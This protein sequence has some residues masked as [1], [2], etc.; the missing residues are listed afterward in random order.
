LKELK[1]FVLATRKDINK[2]VTVYKNAIFYA[3]QNL[4]KIT[5]TKDEGARIANHNSDEPATPKIQ[6][7]PPAEEE[8]EY[9]QELENVMLK[10]EDLRQD[11][12]NTAAFKQEIFKRIDSNLKRIENMKNNRKALL[13]R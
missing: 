3:I 5:E 9:R 11:V 2:E 6:L 12:Q 7:Y 8:A 4:P 1:S 10:I 13:K